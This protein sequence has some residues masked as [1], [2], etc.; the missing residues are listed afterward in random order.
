MNV[1]LFKILTEYEVRLLNLLSTTNSNE[2]SLFTL[3]TMA[4]AIIR[5]RKRK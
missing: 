4:S 5:K 3:T 2:D 1:K